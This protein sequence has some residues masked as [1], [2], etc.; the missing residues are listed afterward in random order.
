MFKLKMCSG[1]FPKVKIA[2]LL[3]T[4]FVLGYGTCQVGFEGG[5]EFS[6]PRPRFRPC[7][8]ISSGGFNSAIYV[9]NHVSN[10]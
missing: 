5:C 7:L 1:D 9:R 6:N 2:K 10:K 4:G 3:T 8:R